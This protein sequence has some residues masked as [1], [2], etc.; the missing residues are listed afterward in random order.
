MMKLLMLWMITTLWKKKK[1]I[2]KWM[3]TKLG[4]NR[5]V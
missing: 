2:G 4:K 1:V 3:T 5:K